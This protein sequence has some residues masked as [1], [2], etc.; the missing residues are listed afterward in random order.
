MVEPFQRVLAKYIKDG[1]VTDTIEPTIVIAVYATQHISGVVLMCFFGGFY[2]DAARFNHPLVQLDLKS[3][4][5]F[6][7]ELILLG[8]HV[9]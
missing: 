4:K 8:G 3:Q 6:P 1:I 2:I 9:L 7:L 5:V